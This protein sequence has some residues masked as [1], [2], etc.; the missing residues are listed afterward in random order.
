MTRLRLVTGP[1]SRRPRTIAEITLLGTAAAL[2]L[3][4]R[5]A[6]NELAAAVEAR[7]PETVLRALRRLLGA[8]GMA[9]DIADDL[10][11]LLY[12]GRPSA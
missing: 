9:G 7:D 10:E 12:P 4:V 3:T 11:H 2:I 5:E 6:N 1:V 8:G